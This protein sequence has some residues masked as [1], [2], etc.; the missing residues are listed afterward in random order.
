MVGQDDNSTGTQ[1][2]IHLRKKRLI[3][4][5]EVIGDVQR[6]SGL[7][8]LQ[9]TRAKVLATAIRIEIRFPRGNVDVAL[10]VGGRTS[11]LLNGPQAT[12]RC[13]I[14]DADSLKSGRIV[15]KQPSVRAVIAPVGAKGDIDKTIVEQDGGSV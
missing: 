8:K 5:C 3:V 12:F 13:R 10:R 14:E 6:A 2:Q 4:G 1:V 9:D 11:S 7:G 15:R